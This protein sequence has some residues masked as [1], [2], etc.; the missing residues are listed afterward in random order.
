MSD[1]NPQNARGDRDEAAE[2]TRESTGK[3]FEGDTPPAQG[4][5]TGPDNPEQDVE[6]RGEG[7]KNKFWLILIIILVLVFIVLA[8]VGRFGG[9]F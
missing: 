2:A 7:S 4:L 5:G 8:V 6:S 3:S 1:V 9:F